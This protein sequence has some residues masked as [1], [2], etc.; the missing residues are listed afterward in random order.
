MPE[1]IAVSSRWLSSWGSGK[2]IDD[3]RLLL[4]LAE[5]TEGRQ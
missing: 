5:L 4:K 2:I 3:S 1:E